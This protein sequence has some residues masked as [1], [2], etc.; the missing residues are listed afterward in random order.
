MNITKKYI[1]VFLLQ[2]LIPGLLPAQQ[3]EAGSFTT[4][5]VKTKLAPKWTLQ[6]EVQA[7]SL[8]FYDK[9]YYYETKALLHYKIAKKYTAALGTGYYKTFEEGPGFDGYEIQKE[10][11]VWEQFTMEHK[12][13]RL[14]LE[15]R[16]RTEQRFKNN[17]E[18]RLRYR[19]SVSIPINHETLTDNTFWAVI[20]NEIFLKDEAPNFAR[21]R[22]QAGLGY[23]F[24]D[25]ISVQSGWLKQVDYNENDN[26]SKDYV[27]VSVSLTI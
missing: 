7:R 4:L 21:N 26:R 14:K 6:G 1:L 17:F 24:N 2:A 8:S 13:N 19:I 15:Q 18:N 11:R 20:Y 16:L 25:N 9:F 3:K 27:L 5:S 23:T 12:L 22:F 10:F